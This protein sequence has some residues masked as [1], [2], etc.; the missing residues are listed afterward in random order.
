[1]LKHFIQDYRPKQIFSYCDF[2]KFDGRSYEAL[3]MQFIGY[4]GPDMKWI[5]P[6]GTVRNRSPKHHKM[7]KE[8]SIGQIYGAGSKKYRLIVNI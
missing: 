1:M 8:A 5:M 7:L 2:N 6:D 3:G 4:T